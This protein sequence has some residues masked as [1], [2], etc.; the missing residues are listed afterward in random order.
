MFERLVRLQQR[1]EAAEAA[2]LWARMGS[3]YSRSVASGP[4]GEQLSL[5][6]DLKSLRSD[7]IIAAGVSVDLAEEAILEN[8]YRQQAQ[9][10]LCLEAAM[11]S[12]QGGCQD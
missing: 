1:I 3:S 6:A 8:T 11:A 2:I 9:V 5:L 10:E 4:T 12:G 7:L